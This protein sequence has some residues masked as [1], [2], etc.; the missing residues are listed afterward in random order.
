MMTQQSRPFGAVD[1]KL[2]RAKF[3]RK[4]NEGVETSF[5]AVNR[6]Q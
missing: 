6:Q 1:R 5:A 3:F 2:W 4:L